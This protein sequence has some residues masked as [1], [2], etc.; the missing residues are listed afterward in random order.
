MSTSTADADLNDYLGQIHRANLLEPSFGSYRDTATGTLSIGT[1][2]T[3]AIP[4]PNDASLVVG[5][6]EAPH[7][8]RNAVVGIDVNVKGSDNTALGHTINVDGKNNIVIGSKLA[9]VG[10]DQ[11]IIGK[12]DLN[13]MQERIVKLEEMAERLWWMPGGPMYQEAEARFK[14]TISKLL[15]GNPTVVDNVPIRNSDSIELE[16]SEKNI[17]PLDED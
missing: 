13:A 2:G 10:D 7:Y 12:L 14:E 16:D 4:D 15:N 3:L 11:V 1:V 9:V 5:R 6:A 8:A 17:K